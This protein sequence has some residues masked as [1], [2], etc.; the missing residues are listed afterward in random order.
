MILRFNCIA[1]RNC[2]ATCGHKFGGMDVEI[3]D[4]DFV[5]GEGEI[6]I[7]SRNVF[8]GYA[9]V[10]SIEIDIKLTFINL[11]STR[12]KYDYKTNTFPQL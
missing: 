11:I 8:M 10:N 5:S 3:L 4:P 7:H 6:V 1:T 2:D 12:S 9:K